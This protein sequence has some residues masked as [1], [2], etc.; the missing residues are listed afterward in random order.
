M[1][2]EKIKLNYIVR[3]RVIWQAGSSEAK[4]ELVDSV[5]NAVV[6][7]RFFS[8]LCSAVHRICF[9]LKLVSFLIVGWTVQCGER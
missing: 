4:P 7:D 8:W 2:D 3:T 6:N 5:L 1:K 9:A